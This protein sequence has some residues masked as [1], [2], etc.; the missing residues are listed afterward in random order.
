MKS[1]FLFYKCYSNC[2]SSDKVEP[3]DIKEVTDEYMNNHFKSLGSNDLKFWS[4]W[5]FKVLF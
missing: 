5:I 2:L 3:A 1:H 4:D